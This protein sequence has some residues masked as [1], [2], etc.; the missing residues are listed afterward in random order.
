MKRN[1]FY[2]CILGMLPLLLG[3]CEND[4]EKINLL[5][6]DSTYPD[7]T[8][9]DIEVIY[10]DSASVRVQLLAEELKQ[11]NTVD[12]PYIEFPEGLHVY[13]YDDSMQIESEIRADYTIYYIEEKLWHARG[14]VIARNIQKGDRLNS[15]ELYW[16]EEKEI[17]YSNTFTRIENEKGTFYGQNGFESNQS[18]TKWRLIGSRGVVNVQED[19]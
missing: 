4:I 17:I 9:E 8:G 2:I 19:E 18:L 1:L 12:E 11:Y 13:F 15:E 10:S 5:T 14:N 16:D 3:S 6:G 7:V